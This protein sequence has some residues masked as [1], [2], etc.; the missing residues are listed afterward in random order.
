M[1]RETNVQAKTR[2]KTAR[3]A[4][5]KTPAVTKQPQRLKKA[6][7]PKGKASVP[8]KEKSVKKTDV[9]KHTVSTPKMVE[10]IRT[11]PEI[12]EGK[13]YMDV[14]GPD[15]QK[16]DSITVPEKIFHAKINA[17]LVSQAVRVYLSNQREGSASTKT[18][19]EVEGSS[20]KLY[21]QKGTGR[22]RHGS[23]RAP[24]Y[25][26]GGIVFGPRPHGYRLALPVKMKKAALASVL[27]SKL[28]EGKVVIV[29]G[30]NET[31]GKTKDMRK[32]MNI[33]SGKRILLFTA[34]ESGLAYRAVRN[35]P[36]VSVFPVGN[37]T[38]YTVLRSDRI[39]FEEEAMQLL[40]KRF[41]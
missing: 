18:R 10:E 32:I 23:I 14:V 22:A 24:I 39:I 37:A 27:T 38:T 1:K 6:I 5:V 11:I 25:V 9:V 16:K 29:R 40:A 33:F 3:S 12:K 35:M 19:G 2:P 26:K 21:K 15:G 17:P 34:G 8:P 31:G 28:N 41:S 4:K 20:R 13:V 36:H 30:L 7:V